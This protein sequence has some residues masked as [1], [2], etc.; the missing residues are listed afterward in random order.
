MFNKGLDLF[1]QIIGFE[2]NKFKMK[3]EDVVL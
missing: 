1:Q 3:R 2:L